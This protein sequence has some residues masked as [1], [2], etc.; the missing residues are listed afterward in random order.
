ME[1]HVSQSVKQLRSRPESVEAMQLFALQGGESDHLVKIN[2][3]W[4]EDAY[5]KK[6]GIPFPFQLKKLRAMFGLSASFMADILGLGSNQY[7]QFELGVLPSASL[8]TLLSFVSTPAKF[9]NYTINHPYLD[10]YTK[11]NIEKRY[12]AVEP[13][14]SQLEVY[15]KLTLFPESI[16]RSEAYQPADIERLFAMMGFFASRYQEYAKQLYRTGLNKLLF[17]ADFL[18]FNRTGRSISGWPYVAIS[19]GPVPDNFQ[20]LIVAASTVGYI[21]AEWTVQNDRAVE[22]IQPG[23]ANYEV[24]FDRDEYETMMAVFEALC[25]YGAKGLA[26][27]SH[28]E[29]AWIKNQ[30]ARNVISYPKY[31]FSLVAVPTEPITTEGMA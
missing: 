12:R 3:V 26:D 23:S 1:V 14:L 16:R 25:N 30:A 5:R 27:L 7:R 24:A 4:V 31:A 9:F 17:Y 8:G 21:N 20:T 11:L 28:N 15:T 6:H 10:D 13:Y 2:N 19:F 22:L 18:H 29:Q